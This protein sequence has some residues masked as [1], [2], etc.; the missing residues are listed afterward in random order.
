MRTV[1]ALL[2][3][4]LTQTSRLSWRD[5]LVVH[6]DD[7]SIE[8]LEPVTRRRNVTWLPA[9]KATRADLARGN[10]LLAGTPETNA[11]I[12]ELAPASITSWVGRA[13][14]VVQTRNDNPMNSAFRM[15]FVVG[16]IDEPVRRRRADVHVR[17][18]GKTILLG[19]ERDDGELET[20]SFALADEPALELGG[21]RFFVHE[22]HADNVDRDELARLVVADAEADVHVYPSLEY[23]GLVTDDTRSAHEEDGTFHVVVGVDDRPARFIAE[24]LM[25]DDAP[26]LLTRGRAATRVYDESTLD[27]YDELARRLLM[28]SEPPSLVELLDNGRFEALSPF[29]TD[30]V[31]ASYGRFVVRHRVADDSVEALEPKWKA[32]LLKPTSETLDPPKTLELDDSFHRGITYAH[33][34]YQ[35]HNGYL[36]ARSDDSLDKLTSLGV[37]SV[38]VVPYAFMSDA[39]AIGPLEVPT[40]AGSETDDDVVHAIS[41]ARER[42]MTVLMKPQIWV[43]RSWPGDITLK[44]ADD[45][46]TFFREYRRWI[47]HYAL[48][49]EAHDVPLLAIGTELKNVSSGYRERWSTII[50]D[51]RCVYDGKLVYAANWGAEVQDVDFWDRLDYIGVDFYYPLSF[52]EHVSDDEL[53]RGFESALDQIRKLHEKHRKPVL[54]TEIGYAS[55]KS[56]WTKPHASDKVREL[57]PDDQARSYS[58]AF[59]ALADETAWIRGMYWWKWPTNLERGGL[60]HRGFTPNGKPAEDVLRRWYGSRLQ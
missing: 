22:T 36:S 54:L 29:I 58:I 2:L 53:T 19:F 9:S 25:D 45:E 50:D 55:T 48:M 17:R 41:R 60:D 47:L 38:A 39:G 30:A 4:S 10:V 56:P 3:V 5:L 32:A 7:V 51:I 12:R 31:S 44:N 33:M 26:T 18:D 52:E 1:L 6:G 16:E 27:R 28:T 21:F 8:D 40:R 34:G 43:R 15:T 59:A 42:G 11:F 23:K 24:R 13:G 14:F 20:R 49:A 35:I 37:D 46:E 57:S